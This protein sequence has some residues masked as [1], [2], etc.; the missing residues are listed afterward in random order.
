MDR[1]LAAG[2]GLTELVQ[3]LL[4]FTGTYRDSVRLTW[5]HLC[6]MNLMFFHETPGHHGEAGGPSDIVSRAAGGKAPVSVFSLC[7]WTDAGLFP[8]E[9][10][11]IGRGPS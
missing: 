7:A 1:S 3:D 5:F 2:G 8:G 9:A 11:T 4:E 6:L 10:S